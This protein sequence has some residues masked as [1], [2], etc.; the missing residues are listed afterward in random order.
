[1]PSY[2]V[3]LDLGQA[4]DFS[5]LAIAERHPG[6]LRRAAYHLRHLERWPLGTSYPAI[7]QAVT[8][9]LGQEPL[10]AGARLVVDG[11]GV[12]RA[13]VDLFRPLGRRLVPVTI[14]GGVGVTEAEDGYLH[15]PKR[16]LIGAAQVLLQDGRLRIAAA[17]PEAATLTAEL[18]DYRVKISASGHD[19]Y[20]AR[21]GAHDDLIL[22]VALAVWYG[23]RAP[24]GL[25]GWHPGAGA[26]GWGISSPQGPE[27]SVTRNGTTAHYPIRRSI[28]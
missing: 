26:T 17:L 23:D 4:H 5:A 13:V 21:E 18:R 27:H 12:G 9:M 28:R 14:T 7:V 24:F 10:N 19:S 20:D 2:L 11:T 6:E 1:L 25:T 15:V 16:D 22:A 3:G 8:A